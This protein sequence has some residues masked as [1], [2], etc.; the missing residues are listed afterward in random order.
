MKTELF[1]T[2]EHGLTWIDLHDPS[3]GELLEAGLMFELPLELIRSCLNASHLP[4]YEE[5]GLTKFILLRRFQCN[6]TAEALTVEDVTEKTAIF[7]NEGFILTV[8]RSSWDHML[9]VRDSINADMRKNPDLRGSHT[10][11]IQ[12]EIV[13]RIL[14]DDLVSFDA[15]MDVFEERF[16]RSE[17]LVFSQAADSRVLSECYHL[18]RQLFVCHRALR[19]NIDVLRKLE[20]AW[21]DEIRILEFYRA[22][23]ERF[24][25]N[26]D[27]EIES[28]HNLLTLHM[29]FQTGHTNEIMRVL[30]VFSAFFMPLTFIAGVYGMNFEHMP[31]LK[32]PFGYLGVLLG[33][34]FISLGIYVYFKKKK[35]IGNQDNIYQI[36]PIAQ[37]KELETEELAKARGYEPSEPKGKRAA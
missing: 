14:H 4:K 24:L 5:H 26:I 3:R 9:R 11:K 15:P 1:T 19:L 18:K 36:Q 32:S 13:Q 2:K 33:M 35:W 12:F 37:T 29:S 16:E 8:H 17:E 30:A 22:D 25:A 34:C 27:T 31:E 23:A 10:D 6:N 7:I 21:H 20:V 28:I